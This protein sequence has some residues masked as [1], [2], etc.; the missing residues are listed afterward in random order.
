M[1]EGT[2]RP[3]HR[4][5][6]LSAGQMALPRAFLFAQ[7]RQIGSAGYVCVTAVRSFRGLLT[8]VH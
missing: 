5:V 7:G 6:D 4:E 2:R 3:R 8:I 1:G